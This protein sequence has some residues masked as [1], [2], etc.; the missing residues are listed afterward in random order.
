VHRRIA[1]FLTS[2]ILLACA[3]SPRAAE[4]SVPEFELRLVDGK[5]VRS[6]DLRG[7]VAVIDFWAT[8]CKPCIDE[9]GAYNRFYR[10]YGSKVVFLALAAD[11]GTD[12]EIRE[13]IR[14]FKIEYPVAA[15]AL[16][17]LDRFGDIVVFPTT[18]V[19]DRDGKLAREFLGVPPGKHEDLRSLIDR[20]LD[21]RR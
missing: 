7:R 16:K 10:D 14:E 13:A 11:S 6:S 1:L 4:R 3:P 12:E 17:E 20:L 21:A 5:V 9:I 19:I 18:W 15:P 8:W 2:V